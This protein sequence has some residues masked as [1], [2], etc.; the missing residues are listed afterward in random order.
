VSIRVVPLDRL[1][2]LFE[3]RPWSFARERRREIDAHFAALQ[4]ASPAL[5]N[6]QVLVLHR[7]EL[8]G[9]VFHGAYLETDFASFITW[10]DWDWPDRT[11]KNC[12]GL[13][14]LRAAD[15][16]FLLGV[17][18]AHTANAGKI[19]FPGGTPDPHDIIDG[20]V[21]LAASIER[22]LMEETGL[23]PQDAAPEAGWH[24]V[25]EGQRI[26]MLKV[27]QARL[28][29]RELQVRVRAHLASQAQ[30]ELADIRVVRGPEDFD[31][32]MPPFVPAFLSHMWG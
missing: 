15:G 6:G 28:P 8:L 32:M 18:G 23:S 19:Y 14:A 3:P 22:E 12:F 9:R 2:L 10:R 26:A 29:A 16:P 4:R 31:P 5:W 17:M 13:G 7:F 20:R 1:E 30:P 11:V 21:E 24:A 25:L 27:L